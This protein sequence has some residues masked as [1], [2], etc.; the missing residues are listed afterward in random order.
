[1]RKAAIHPSK[2]LAEL[3][4]R[5]RE[6]LGLSL[7]EVEAR[8]GTAGERVHFATLAR[9]EQ[10]KTDLGVRRLYRLFKLYDLPI[11]LAA[12]LLDLEENAESV[13]LTGSFEELGR[14][15]VENWK[16]GNI[17]EALARFFA[18]RTRTPTGALERVSRQKALL[19]MA[20]AAGSLG[21]LALARYIVEDLLFEPPDESILVPALT[22]AAKCWRGLGSRDGA[23]GLLARAEARLEPRQHRERAWVFHEKASILAELGA[24][25]PAE[26][27]LK[28]AVAAYRR[29]RDVY[30]ESTALGVHVKLL[31]ERRDWQGARRAARAA[32]VL[33]RGRGFKRL[34]AVRGLDEARAL[35]ELGRSKESLALLRDVLAWAIQ[36][37]DRILR[38]YAHHALFKA[39]EALGDAVR[40][41]AEFR[42]AED[43]A[44]FVDEVTP[45]T[46]EVRNLRSSAALEVTKRETRV[47]S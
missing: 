36:E 38:F 47:A 43:H 11:Q 24:F 1:M 20:V 10:G 27:A 35:Q 14:E 7:R 39:Y 18:A 37:D 6:E 29:A 9:A 28:T 46:R 23:L 2:V 34:E 19:G 15:G 44:Q 16:S 31:R 45:E 26:A 8:S 21:R 41:T 25:A 40:A 33:A 3:L 4:R 12:D 22:Q 13:V 30:G 42:A 17:R 32:R 5:R